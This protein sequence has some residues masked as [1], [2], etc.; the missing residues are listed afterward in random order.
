[1]SDKDLSQF[2]TQNKQ[3]IGHALPEGIDEM[4]RILHP[5]AEAFGFIQKVKGTSVLWMTQEG[6]TALMFCII[7]DPRDLDR[8]L[9]TYVQ[10]K[11]HKPNLTGIFVHQWTDGE[12]NWEA[13]VITPRYAI[14]HA[15]RIEGSTTIQERG[16]QL[17]E[18]IYTLFSCDRE[19]PEPGCA[20][21][22]EL[23]AGPIDGVYDQLNTLAAQYD[24]EQTAEDGMALWT[25][26]ND[27]LEAAFF[28]MAE[29][30]Y[31]E[32]VIGIYEY[33]HQSGCPISFVFVECEQP[34]LYDIFRLSARSYLEHHNQAKAWAGVKT[35]VDGVTGTP[36]KQLDNLY[37]TPRWSSHV[38][39]IKGC[40]NYLGIVVSDAWLFGATGH[41]FVLNISPGL[42]PS[43]PTD[44]DTSRFLKLGRNIGYI[45]ECLDEYCPKHN[46]HL[47]QVHEQAW[48]FIRKA[49]D[50]N[51]PCYGWEL[52][53]PEYF[54]IYG[55]N[56]TGYYISGPGCDEG[57]GPVPWQ[58]LGK[59]EI[60]M[61]LVSSVRPT[62]PSDD[63]KT[64]R[65]A[66]T[67]A[68]DLGYNRQKWM[69]RSGGLKG[70]DTWIHVM[71]TGIAGRF[72]LGYNAAVWAESRRFAV[73]F[74]KEAQK[75][76]DKNLRSLFNTAIEHYTTVAQNLKVVSDTYPFKKCEDEQTPIDDK[77]DT[78]I[79]TL[80]RACDAEANGLEVLA[81]LINQLAYDLAGA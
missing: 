74:L 29:P 5:S 38:G 60:G 30:S 26:S 79:D 27:K 52:D 59:S 41:A 36:S 12:N 35:K 67:Y 81:E 23:L 7:P 37:W 44:W 22:A 46:R 11:E 18:D 69:D 3:A 72:G 15:D 1:M 56:Q 8:I 54:V 63:R 2:W 32:A 55:Y 66:L 47:H 73:E 19:F 6:E 21:W 39:C 42:C 28:V 51:R 25:G 45:V 31:V 50:K 17:R 65:E 20:G 76:L 78:A 40:L 10:V 9:D 14:Q 43:G 61:V 53:I 13:F 49:I 57:K 34:G 24:C 80:R 75:R 64:V 33:I 77:A 70:Y 48:E 68:M 16:P 58:E 4:A 71:E 62:T